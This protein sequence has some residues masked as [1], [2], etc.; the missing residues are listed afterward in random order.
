[1]NQNRNKL[2]DLFIGNLANAVLHRI[3]EKAIKESEIALR[4]QKE[5][6]NSWQIAK[7]YRDKINPSSNLPI[8]DSEYIKEKIV[9]RVKSE[10][11]LRI[12]K[13]YQNLDLESVEKEVNNALEEL[14]AIN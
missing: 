9:K 13:G 6:R 8:K 5:V 4:Y 10:L 2:I 14:K 1:M 12:N 11:A 7:D 3:L